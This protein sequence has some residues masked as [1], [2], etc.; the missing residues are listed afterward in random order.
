MILSDAMLGR[1]D[2]G[3]GP[4]LTA[5]E[6]DACVDVAIASLERVLEL[7]P[8]NDTAAKK[9]WQIRQHSMY[10]R[11]DPDE[12]LRLGEAVLERSPHDNEFRQVF[13]A[14]LIGGVRFQ[15]ENP[16]GKLFDSAIGL[17]I[18]ER[19]IEK[20]L[21]EAPVG[22]GLYLQA[23]YGMSQVYLY[24]G[25][26]ERAAEYLERLKPY[27][28]E[29][30]IESNNLLDLGL[31]YYRL[32]RHDKAAAAF[33]LSYEKKETP[34]AL[35]LLRLAYEGMGRGI[36]DLP[37]QYRFQ[38]RP[39]RVDPARPPRLRFVDVGPALGVAKLDGAGPSAFADYDGDGD[40]DILAA[41]CDTFTALYRNDGDRF[42]DVTIEAGLGKLESG[43]STN[44]VDYDDDGDLDIYVAR[45]GWTGD[46]PNI[47]MRNRGDGTFEDVSKESGLDDPGC[48]FVSLWADF[49][50]DGDLDVYIGN[51]VLLDGDR[52]RLYANQGDGTFR[53]VTEAAGLLEPPA[54]STIGVAVGDVDLD[55]DPDIFC[56]GRD[57][58]P[59]RLYRNRG[60]GT[61]DEVAE[62]AGLLVPKHDGYVAFIVDLDNDG[63]P[64][65]L[66]T[67]LARW[68]FV[69]RGQMGEIE[70][71]TP[72][73]LLDDAQR[74]FRNKGDGTF[75]D[76]TFAA[77][78]VYPH[79]VMGANVGDFDNDGWLDIILGTGS[80]DV[81]RLEPTVLYRNRGD[82]T[83]QDL[84]RTA[85]IDHL[86][87]G[88]GVSLADY[89][90][91]GDL[92]IYAPQGGFYHGDLW[93]N[94]LYRNEAGSEN[95]WLHVRLVGV[96]SNH[97]AVG[98]RVTAVAGDLRQMREVTGGIGFG[99]TNS[100]PVEF[101]LGDRTAV[102]SVEIRWPSGEVQRLEA[103]PVNCLIEVVEGED[104]WK[105]VRRPD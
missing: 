7:E 95:H 97:F 98:A 33:L 21:D 17:E 27:R 39:E 73:E 6:E 92:D 104:G 75:E 59:N 52:N 32:G 36:T 41:G 18:A 20:I 77:G 56:N 47:L 49:D 13:C 105:V 82:G 9:L 90:G 91:D 74:F 63:L 22:S 85:G 48:G 70:P 78:L 88:H 94:P 101:G 38:L 86:G 45:T 71:R 102:D 8:S 53:D 4:P 96:R 72:E 25:D 103:P 81:K 5:E 40:D 10:R 30:I 37:E 67:S 89:D 76:V 51:G 58:F 34:A 2:M 14:W 46:A 44:L 23:V 12:A 93:A 61:F 83:F 1:R 19:Q 84:S 43:F 11:Y 62:R 16:E 15:R 3:G 64:D 87:K 29:P 42:T 24:M 100:Y 60:D 68:P 28:F 80:P 35:W 50:L 26:F 54:W 66:A 79:G 31:A 65:I 69:L 99:S 57:G 55:G